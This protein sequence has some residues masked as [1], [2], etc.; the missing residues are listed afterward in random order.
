[1]YRK[2]LRR[3]ITIVEQVEYIYYSILLLK[4]KVQECSPGTLMM[5]HARPN[6]AM[7]QISPFK[8]N[9]TL[10]LLRNQ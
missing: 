9:E 8:E 10:H 5:V 6:V 7:R 2:G 1:M 4:Y 3:H